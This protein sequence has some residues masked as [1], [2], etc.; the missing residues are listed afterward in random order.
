MPFAI[1]LQEI[2]SN[3]EQ[4][5]G[6]GG[7]S[8]WYKIEFIA[9]NMIHL[10]FLISQLTCTKRRCFIPGNWK[11]KPSIYSDSTAVSKNRFIN[12]QFSVKA[13]LRS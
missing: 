11:A 6:V 10:P 3:P 5:T 1:I 13:I 2:I 7:I 9:G 8:S 4:A 12:Q